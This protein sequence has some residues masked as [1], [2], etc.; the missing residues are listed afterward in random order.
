MLNRRSGS[1]PML[2][3]GFSLIELMISVV[4][5]MIV[6]AGAVSLIVA[7]DASN[8]QM[9]KSTRLTQELRAL[10]AVVADDIKR[11]RRLDDPIAKVGQGTANLCLTTLPAQ[12]CYPI[13]PTTGN[14]ASC[15]TYGYT[16]T[17]ASRSIYNYKSI[18]LVTTGG[19]GS[20]VMDQLALDPDPAVNAAGTALPADADITSCPIVGA[21]ASIQLTSDQID[22]TDLTFTTV[23]ST[24]IDL[25]V[26]ARL[27]ASEQDAL[28]K[29]TGGVIER[30]FVQP[31]Y[32]RPD[33]VN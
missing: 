5:G 11:T 1:I 10:A 28:A 12:P 9:I 21:D 27:V 16:G 26:K 8:S 23:S 25:S 32:L 31:I 17:T 18:R 6:A 4:I 13:T 24:E 29:S 14:S 30:T 3:R 19:V 15:V 33:P 2:A 22:V 20:V 7:I